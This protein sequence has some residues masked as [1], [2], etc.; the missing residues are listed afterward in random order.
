MTVLIQQGEKDQLKSELKGMK[1]ALR[2]QSGAPVPG[3]QVG[4]SQVLNV[5][6]RTIDPIPTIIL[7]ARHNKNLV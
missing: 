6:I 7:T 2:A 3:Q 1:R 5:N 4:Q